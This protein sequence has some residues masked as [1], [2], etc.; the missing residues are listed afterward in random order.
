MKLMGTQAEATAR[1]MVA[2][3]DLPITWQEFAALCKTL[4]LQEMGNV[5]LLPGTYKPQ[6][7]Y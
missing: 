1:T 2:E 7:F 3:Y 6:A 5:E 4:V